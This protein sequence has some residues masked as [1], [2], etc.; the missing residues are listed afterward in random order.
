MTRRA[1]A[2]VAARQS[3]YAPFLQTETCGAECGLGIAA[4]V[5]C[6]LKTFPVFLI[7]LQ[8]FSPAVEPFVLHLDTE[9]NLFKEIS[10]ILKKHKDICQH[11]NLDAGMKVSVIQYGQ[12]IEKISRIQMSANMLLLLVRIRNI[13]LLN[14]V[15][16]R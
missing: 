14:S 16:P 1:A 15:N 2:A 8:H 12:S 9:A 4:L 11:C 7:L 5:V 6:F 13:R 10:D 3:L